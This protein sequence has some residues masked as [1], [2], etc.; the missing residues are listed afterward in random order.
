MDFSRIQIGCTVRGKIV[1]IVE[2]EEKMFQGG[3][4]DYG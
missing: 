4:Q 1:F 3:H 2:N